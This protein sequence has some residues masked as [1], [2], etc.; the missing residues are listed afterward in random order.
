MLS[1][2]PL[3]GYGGTASRESQEKG[4]KW[5]KHRV[6]NYPP[7]S[8][9]QEVGAYVFGQSHKNTNMSKS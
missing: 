8:D 4:R 1:Q 5:V 6:R 3:A 9:F 2:T 7:H